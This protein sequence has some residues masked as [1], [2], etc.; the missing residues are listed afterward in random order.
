LPCLSFP[1]FLRYN[2]LAGVLQRSLFILVFPKEK[3]FEGAEFLVKK[4]TGSFHLDEK[5]FF[6]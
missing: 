5:E 3:L 1:S 2:A 6:P 4:N